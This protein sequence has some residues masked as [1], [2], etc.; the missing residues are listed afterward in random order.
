MK[1]F[2]INDRNPVQP[3]LDYIEKWLGTYDFTLDLVLEACRR[4]MDRL[5]K[6]NFDYADKILQ[7]WSEKKVHTL[8]MWNDWIRNIRRRT[9]PGRS[10]PLQGNRIHQFPAA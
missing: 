3:E 7:S 6:P 10:H 1:A 4:T 8:A 9:V 5:H 2:G